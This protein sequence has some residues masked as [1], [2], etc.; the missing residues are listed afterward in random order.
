MQPPLFRLTAL[1]N[2]LDA[3]ECNT[4]QGFNIS[5]PLPPTPTVNDMPKSSSTTSA[6]PPAAPLSLLEKIGY[7]AGDTASNIFFQ[8]VNI[9]LFYFYTD[10]WGVS[11]G[12][13]GTIYL[14]TRLWDAVNDPLMG[15]VAD[16]TRTRFGSYRPWLLWMA[17]PFGVI[18][19]ATFASPDLAGNAKIIY[20][21]VTYVLLGM[22]YTAINVPYSALMGVMTSSQEERTL[23]SS[24]RFVG[25]FSAMFLVSLG[26]RPLVRFFGQGDEALG[27]RWTFALFAVIAAL[28]F[29]FTFLTTRERLPIQKTKVSLKKD[30]TGLLKNRP[31]LIMVFAGIL[32]LS[33]VAVRSAVTTHF[34]KYYAGDDGNPFFWFLDKTSLILSSGALA[35][36]V[37]I[38]FT[39]TLRKKFGKRNS[40]I[41]LT[42]LNALTMLAFYFIPADAYGTMLVINALGNLLAGPTPALVWAIYTDVADYG[43][44]KFGHRSTALVFSAAMFAQKLGMTI[45]GTA[46]GWML[47]FFGFVANQPQSDNALLGI[48]ILFSLLPAG[49]GLANAIVLTRYPL[50]ENE[51]AR[52]SAELSQRREN[53]ETP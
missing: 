23:L 15:M 31:W 49:L 20:V 42:L 2:G 10:V 13:V 3:K 37:G 7:G 32:T 22:C 50:D 9:F 29:L 38:F 1:L 12:V 14:V 18:G 41:A 47:D 26:V 40:L 39:N 11:P 35:F 30:V 21:V 34:F 8:T 51:T 46:T 48:R 25:A 4:L 19:F 53:A 27:F 44:W 52:I 33:N 28:L 36:I 16:R 6:P 43:E 5:F 24:F 17:V 45:G